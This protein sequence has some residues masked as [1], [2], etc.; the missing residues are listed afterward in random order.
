MK[1][2][3]LSILA[4]ILVVLGACFAWLYYHDY[5]AIIFVVIAILLCIPF[6]EG[7]KEIKKRRENRNN[8]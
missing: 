8:K 2:L 7:L 6:E 4:C 5:V 1:Q 3:I